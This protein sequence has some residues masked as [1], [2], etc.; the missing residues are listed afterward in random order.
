MAEAVVA[1]AGAAAAVLVRERDEVAE[2]TRQGAKKGARA[3]GLLGEAAESAVDAAAGVVTDAARK[4]LPEAKKPKR[5]TARGG[6]AGGRR[7]AALMDREPSLTG[8]PRPVERRLVRRYGKTATGRMTLAAAVK[9]LS[10]LVRRHPKA[11]LDMAAA[12]ALKAGRVGVQGLTE[13]LGRLERPAAAEPR[14]P[15]SRRERRRF[16]RAL[17]AQPNLPEI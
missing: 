8:L 2:A 3:F 7:D 4:M 9:A 5:R 12:A 15:L 17:R 11:A 14:R 1:G 13:R 16:L 6:G 10:V